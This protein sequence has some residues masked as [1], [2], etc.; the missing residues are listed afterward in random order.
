MYYRD[1]YVFKLR[2]Y[3]GRLKTL[4]RMYR[5]FIVKDKANTCLLRKLILMSHIKT[6]ISYILAKCHLDS[7]MISKRNNDCVPL[8][9][10]NLLYKII[11]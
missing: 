8:E 2:T 1:P 7:I 4:R 5:D 3:L 11:E 6:I 9:Y 10:K